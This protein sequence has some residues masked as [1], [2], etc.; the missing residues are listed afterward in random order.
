MLIAS[1]EDFKFLANTTVI[2]E[3]LVKVVSGYQSG[4]IVF[5]IKCYVR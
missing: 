5:N 4:K 1:V 3:Q 2:V